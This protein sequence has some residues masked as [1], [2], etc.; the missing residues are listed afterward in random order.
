MDCFYINLASAVQRKI[1]LENN[2]HKNKRPGWTLTRFPAI[3]TEFVRGQNIAGG[4]SAAE[5]ACFLSHKKAIG[6][7]LDDRKPAFVLEDD[8]LFGAQSCAII[9]DTLRKNRDLDW[10]VLYTDICIPTAATM[11]DLVKLRQTLATTNKITLMDLS[12]IPFAGATAYIVNAKSKRKMVELLESATEINVPYDLYV[13]NLIFASALKG[14]AVFPFVTSLSDFSESSQ[15][16]NTGTQATALV[17]NTFRKMIWTERSLGDCRAAL[18][19]IEASLGDEESKAFGTLFSAMASA[20]Y[21]T[22]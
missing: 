5:K 3:D 14:F 4:S 6:L 16:Q 19:S 17:W 12:K 2:F 18:A 11:I 8:A 7:N 1:N 9:D 10:D 21:K 20:K 15:I 22:L 13:R